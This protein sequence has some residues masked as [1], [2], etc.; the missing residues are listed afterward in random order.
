MIKEEDIMHTICDKSTKGF[1]KQISRFHI[2]IVLS[3]ALL[4]AGC[5]S[6]PTPA[7]QEEPS[8]LP[9][10]TETSSTPIDLAPSVVRLPD[11]SEISME[12]DA[13]IE[14]LKIAGLSSGES[15]HEIMLHRGEI[16]VESLLP[17]GEWFTV[18]N[19]DYYYARVSGSIFI[20]FYDPVSDQFMI[21]CVSGDCE[22]GPD[23]QNIVGIVA[24]QMGCLDEEGNFYGPYS[25][26]DFEELSEVCVFSEQP[27]APTATHTET[28]TPEP[29]VASDEEATATAA[30]KDFESQ[31]PGTPCP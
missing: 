14:I 24:G 1:D 8:A 6:T 7:T 22:M 11:G 15:G 3:I 18:V 9:Q 19:R 28:S 23:L 26:I 10:A 2:L 4:L 5:S 20:V 12:S 25:D 31:F 13:Y 21:E 29:S 16:N 17:Q 27:E 30:C